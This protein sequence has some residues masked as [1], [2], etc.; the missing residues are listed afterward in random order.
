MSYFWDKYERWINGNTGDKKIWQVEDNYG[1][2]VCW[3]DVRKDG[4]VLSKVDCIEGYGDTS[5]SPYPNGKLIRKRDG[6]YLKN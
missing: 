6:L 1:Y 5:K 4:K 2:A 3:A